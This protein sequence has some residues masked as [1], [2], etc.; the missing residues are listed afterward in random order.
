MEVQKEPIA[1][2][3]IGCRFPGGASSP[4]AFWNLLKRGKDA[5]V[6]IPKDRWDVRRFYDKNPD[7]PGK[8]YVKQGGFLKEKI[9]RFDP[10]F[11]G[12]SPREAET[13]DPQQRLLLEVT[14]EAFEDAGI[15]M[16]QVRGSRTGVFIGGFCLDS[17]LLR[18]GALN[19]D[20]ADS[21]S[22]ASSTMTILSNRI[23][24]IFDLKGPSV[25]MDTACSSSLVATHYACQSIWSGEADT[26]L[27]GGVN[28]MLRPEF[29]IMM[30]KGKFLS[31]HGRCKAFDADASGYSRGEGSGIVVLKPMS[32]AEEDGDR[33]YGLIKETGVNQD[34]HTTGISLPN[35][36]SQEALAREVYRNA[37]VSPGEIEYVEAHGTGTQAG[38]PAEINALDRV[39]SENRTAGSKCLVGSVKTN[40]GHLE[41][42]AGIAGLIKGVLSLYHE[43]I[44]ANLH[45]EKPN[46]KIPFDDLCIQVATKRKNWKRNGKVRYAGV[47]SFG[48]GGTNAHVLLEEAP[49]IVEKNVFQEE[50]D[51]PFILPISGKCDAAVRE[52]AGKYSFWL[53]TN[54]SPS[55]ISN[56]CYS[57]SQRRSHH[58]NR[59]AVV[60]NS[61]DNARE[62]LQRYSSGKNIEGVV[63]G[64]LDSELQKPLVFVYTGMGPQ[65]WAMGRELYSSEAIFQETLNQCDEVF[66][67]EAGW[68]ILQEMLAEEGQSK[69]SRTEVAQPANFMIQNGLTALWKSWGV[70]PDAVIGHSVGEVG[71]AFASGALSL[72]DSIKV[73]YHRSRLQQTLAGFG[74]MLAVGMSEADALDLIVDF[75][76]VSIAAINAPSAVTL[77]GASSQ[78]ADIESRLKETSTFC[79]PLKVE[80]AYHSNQMNPI[81]GEL[82]ECLKSISPRRAQVPLYSTVSG[83]GV[84]GSEF[85]AKYWWKNVREPVRFADGIESL[86]ESGYAHFLE[87]GP[88]PVLGHSIKEIAQANSK[89]VFV[90][91]SLSRKS[92]DKLRLLESLGALFVHGHNINWEQIIP[93]GG[94]Y[95]TLPNYPWQKDVYWRESEES[96]QDRFGSEELVFLN[97]R[98]ASPL[99]T[100]T[101]EV[102]DQFFPFLEDHVVNKQVVFPG[103]GYIEIGFSLSRKRSGKE[104]VLLSD[105]RFSNM[106]VI[107]G[108][109]SQELSSVFNEETNTFHAYSRS[110]KAGSDWILHATGAV[111]DSGYA[112]KKTEICLD[113]LR[114]LFVEEIDVNRMYSDLA[115][116]G[117][118]YGG[119]FR[120]SKHVW[121]KENEILAKIIAPLASNKFVLSPEI[122][123]SAFHSILAVVD[124]NQPY[125]PVEVAKVALVK[126]FDGECWLRGVVTCRETNAFY[127]DFYMYNGV[128]ELCLEVKNA[129][130]K[131]LPNV[132][133]LGRSNLEGL[134]YAPSWEEYTPR[135]NASDYLGTEVVVISNDDPFVAAV[136]ER[137]TAT[138]VKF[139]RVGSERRSEVIPSA[140]ISMESKEGEDLELFLGR[141]K[142]SDLVHLLYLLPLSD[143]VDDL[144][145]DEMVSSC[146]SVTNVAR[147]IQK[148]GLKCTL[149]LVTK[150][151]QVLGSEIGQKLEIGNCA[152]WGF[153]AVIEN[154][155]QGVNCRMVDIDGRLP[156][157]S[158]WF[159]CL[160]DVNV[161][162]VVFRSGKAFVRSLKRIDSESVGNLEPELELISENDQFAV[163][164]SDLRKTN[165]VEF[166]NT[167]RELPA[168][169]ELEVK[170]HSVCLSPKLGNAPGSNEYLNGKLNSEVF[171]VVVGIGD[172]V[173]PRLLGKHV[174]F[175]HDKELR[176]YVRVSCAK[177]ILKLGIENNESLF[178]FSDLA[179]AYVALVKIAQLRKGEK[180]LIHEAGSSLG[181]A[182]LKIAEN[183]GAEPLLVAGDDDQINYLR[184]IQDRN[185]FDSRY[186]GF[187]EEI[188]SAIGGA[189]VDVLFNRLL[190]DCFQESVST[191]SHFSRCVD[192]GNRQER[193]NVD[194]I[195]RKNISYTRV[196]F[197]RMFEVDTGYL[198]EVCSELK[199]KIVD[200]CDFEMPTKYWPVCNLKAAINSLEGTRLVERV[201][202]GFQDEPVEVRVVKKTQKKSKYPGTYI[203][204]GG[205][206]GFGLEVGR[207]LAQNGADRV[208]LLSR[209]GVLSEQVDWPEQMN[210]EIVPR[211]LDVTQ[212]DQVAALI[213]EISQHESPLRGVVHG[214]MVLE[215]HFLEDLNKENYSKVMAPKIK[216][217]MNLY[218][219]TRDSNLDFFVAFS[220]ISSL[221]GNRG[222]ANYIAANAFLDTFC[223]AAAVTG[224]PA[225]TINWGALAEAGVVARNV[226]VGELLEQEGIKGLSTSIALSAFDYVLNSNFRQ[227]GFFDVDWS[228]WSKVN[229]S[230]GNSSRLSN[231]VD[232]QHDGEKLALADEIYKTLRDLRGDEKFEYIEA[233]AKKGLGSVLKIPSDKIDSN[234]VLSEL[235]IDSL[236]LIEL[237]LTIKDDFGIN[238]PAAELTKYP[239]IKALTENI[240][241][242]LEGV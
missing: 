1:I 122:L 104:K 83:D 229:S 74:G 73:S 19:R 212:K 24:Y 49:E 215:D 143:R 158:G 46:P 172:N 23:S 153:G 237:A 186:M 78:L 163:Q 129:H 32:K 191:L 180:V 100:W 205:T 235:G 103:A 238:I 53:S 160:M 56:F 3:G 210:G 189:K 133:Q 216:G 13:M 62:K 194:E 199:E 105:L 192:L 101:V 44:V 125:V 182:A 47:N 121:I 20:F 28:V 135:A 219:L 64:S 27:A 65:W 230:V 15:R 6:D 168:V 221:I 241:V 159:Q 77:S 141:Y 209:R 67:E 217:T 218:E 91:S 126:E 99:P 107:E 90:T 117:L 184:S 84:D 4:K 25:T 54:T 48:Y 38:D 187:A 166:I 59:T 156:S 123:D 183:A 87:I 181:L 81:E 131:E 75:D 85:G 201:V 227:L 228:A 29:P 111:I 198:M 70:E 10:L 33:I 17:M 232:T 176:R 161:K 31:Q 16:E 37:G 225:K 88:H 112:L 174:L 5:I 61:I 11:F 214:A 94:R 206:G 45:F 7:K 115:K 224:Y 138:G 204:T 139:T 93:A 72:R 196:D 2:V 127:C 165:G 79:R 171:G 222:Q 119:A 30:S 8:T 50:Y 21:H 146:M 22:A 39:L 195:L 155:C 68:S 55:A 145:F 86:L 130:M 202:I 213:E 148:I 41:A 36:K 97:Q 157:F 51:G 144:D 240:I 116:R 12:I 233:L 142:K 231:L 52:L 140:G 58:I 124:G 108:G 114:A 203:I 128:G 57:I 234:Q 136:C 193:F 14:W 162:D 220:S 76:D 223:H 211:A 42:S 177:A 169:D 149:T 34:G 26:A 179:L 164:Q 80:V 185:V 82:V 92:P 239:N 96:R 236:L 71:S 69:M 178:L 134:M 147:S 190:D 132:A 98:I 113:E 118:N 226:K 18:L 151:S 89:K 9:D 154:E 208:F 95:T 66:R 150:N 175:K 63:Q 170:V 167:D 106:L 137:M 200:E 35:S 60:A 207:H 120:C 173:E 40:I 197:D 188:R 43:M 110:K 109:E 242:R 152:L 102:N